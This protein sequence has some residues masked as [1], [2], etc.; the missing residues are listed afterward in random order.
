MDSCLRS[1]LENLLGNPS[2]SI[3]DVWLNQLISPN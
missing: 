1:W 3:N 2:T